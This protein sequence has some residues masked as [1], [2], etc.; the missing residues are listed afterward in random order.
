MN[1]QS[2]TLQPGL[3][4]VH[5]KGALPENCATDFVFSYPIPSSL[6]LC[7]RPNTMLYGTAPYMAGKGAPG[8]LILVDDELRPQL[9]TTFKD[10]FETRNVNGYPWQLLNGCPAVVQEYTPGNTRAQLQ[11]AMFANRYNKI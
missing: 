10:D 2:R 3:E 9:T 11:N 6:N 8:D 1:Q 4:L 5:N 7:C